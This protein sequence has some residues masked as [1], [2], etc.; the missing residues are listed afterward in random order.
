MALETVVYGGQH[1]D[2]RITNWLVWDQATAT[3]TAANDRK[4]ILSLLSCTWRESIHGRHRKH[5]CGAN[6]TLLSN[7]DHP[8]GTHC[9]CLQRTARDTK[10]LRMSLL[11]SPIEGRQRGN[12]RLKKQILCICKSLSPELWPPYRA[13]LGSSGGRG[14]VRYCTIRPN[15][16]WILT[17]KARKGRVNSVLCWLVWSFQEL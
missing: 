7:N 4:A 13:M 5:H 9:H 3:H 17:G 12:R 8:G 10:R 1:P 14:Q 11:S 16:L 6:L 15:L 2:C